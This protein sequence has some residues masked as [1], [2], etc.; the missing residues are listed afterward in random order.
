LYLAIQRAH[1]PRRAAELMLKCD[2]NEA[3]EYLTW[4]VGDPGFFVVFFCFTAIISTK[5]ARKYHAPNRLP[6]VFA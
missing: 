5:P 1:Y 4:T 2:T 3:R 6:N